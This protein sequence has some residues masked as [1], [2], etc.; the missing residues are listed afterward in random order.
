MT[1]QELHAI[2]AKGILAPSGDN[3]QPWKFRLLEDGV[4]L[5]VTMGREPHFFEAGFRTLYFSA[6]AVIENMRVAAGR[7]GYRSIPSYFPNMSDP[8]FVVTV[9]FKREDSRRESDEVLTRRVTNRKFYDK[10]RQLEP[11]IFQKLSGVVS[12]EKGF[13]L[14]WIKKSEPSYTKI[15]KIIGDSDQI[16]F[17]NKKI[18]EDLPPTLRFSPREAEE[19]K[20]GLDLRTFETGPGGAFL[21]KLI[22]SWNRL[23]FLNFLGMSRQFNNYARLQMMS[24][25]AC[26]LIVAPGYGPE[27]YVLGGE[28][29]ERVWHEMTRLGLSIQP[30]ESLPVFTIN[31]QL[32]GGRDFD[33]T[34]KRK[35]MKLKEE[36]YSLYG[37]G[38][39]RGVIFL[40]RVGYADPPSARSLRRPVESFLTK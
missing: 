10:N 37:I 21:F 22:S 19:T 8:L 26:G 34:Q 5:Y 29:T 33:E 30:M 7:L 12:S 14:L 40:F 13:Q 9:R 39:Q 11:P 35:V 6:G 27:D 36:L 25:Q 3:T 16:R 20:D 38:E 28:V 31:L 15:C 32:N 18:Y 4:E 23:K 2:I 17:E 24:S 1:H